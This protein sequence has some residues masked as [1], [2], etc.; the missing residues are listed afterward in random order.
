VGKKKKTMYGTRDSE[1]GRKYKGPRKKR[2]RSDTEVVTHS[3]LG[4]LRPRID[5]RVKLRTNRVVISL[6]APREASRGERQRNKGEA[7]GERRERK[8]YGA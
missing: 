6:G 3:E 7:G 8:Q 2:I 4:E 1:G 5:R